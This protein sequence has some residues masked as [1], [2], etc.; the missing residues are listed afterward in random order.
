MTSDSDDVHSDSL[1]GATIGA[2]ALSV[3]PSLRPTRKPRWFALA[4][5]AA[6]GAAIAGA[7]VVYARTAREPLL[8]E[9]F[10]VEG[11]TVSYSA[12]F[13][14]SAGIRTIEVHEAAFAPIVS[15]TGKAAFD[16]ERVAQIGASVLGTVR[17]V[18]KYEGD[19]VKRGEVLAEIGSPL[20]ARRDAASSLR[21]REL[22]HG[23]LGVSQLRSP[24]DGLV[25]ERRIVTGQSVRGEHVVFVVANLDRLF[26]DV[27]LDEQQA[28]PLRVGDRVDV[29]RDAAPGACSAGLVSE[30]SGA[31]NGQR[32][33]RV[34]VDNRARG[35]RPGEAVTARIFASF[36]GRALLIPNRALASIA[37]HPVVFVSDG[38]YSASAASVTL[39]SGDGEQ[40]EVRFG[41]ASGQHIVSE[42]VPKLK[43]ASFL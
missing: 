5:W 16:P 27:E 38:R 29:S 20:Q 22:P 21:A 43:E 35:L 19:A 14:A 30:L 24:L 26:V 33:V 31:A 34:G 8:P 13:A 7:L 17:R 10:H 1:S 11:R 36:G 28:S 40:T 39:G 9:A 18:A 37:G 15:G 3:P 42:G 12:S 4:A 23:T 32:R 2:S 6:G 25:I 41:L